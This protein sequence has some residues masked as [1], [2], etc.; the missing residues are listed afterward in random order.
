MYDWGVLIYDA[1]LSV[2]TCLIIYYAGLENYVKFEH[3]IT[4]SC[5]E[6]YKLE[7]HVI[8][9]SVDHLAY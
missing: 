7:Y 1:V 4:L 9:F 5:V 6:K 8:F 2:H 3:F